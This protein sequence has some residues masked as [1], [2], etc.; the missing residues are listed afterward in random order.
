MKGWGLDFG[1]CLFFRVKVTNPVNQCL[2]FSLEGAETSSI[3]DPW[4]AVDSD[5]KP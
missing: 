5:P 3:P 4:E 2:T 1:S